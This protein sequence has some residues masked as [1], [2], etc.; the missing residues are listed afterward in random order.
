MFFDTVNSLVRVAVVG[1]L[2]Y[3]WLIVVLRTTGK[4]T[5]A[6]FNAFDF[7]VTVALGSTLATSIL[8]NA[9]S[10][11]EG[12]VV[13]T[14]LAVLQFAVAW[15]ARRIP[16]FRRTVTGAPT[17]LLLNGQILTDNLSR[18]RMSEDSLLAAVRS[19]GIGGLQDVAAVVL[20]TNGQVSVISARHTGSGSAL[21]DIPAFPRSDRPSS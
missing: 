15:L 6:Q 16:A 21:A 2:A 11:A 10:W 3:L 20:E 13:L 7:I 1:T 9:V 18:Q 12:A 5:L 8:S 4:R 19:S 17:L 14:L